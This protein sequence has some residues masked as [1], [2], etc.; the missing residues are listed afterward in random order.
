MKSPIL[1]TIAVLITIYL[2][3]SYSSG[4]LADEGGFREKKEVENGSS[5]AATVGDV[6]DG[7]DTPETFDIIGSG[8]NGEL[9][10]KFT[11]EEIEMNRIIT[12]DRNG[13][14]TVSTDEEVIQTLKRARQ[15]NL[16]FLRDEP[17]FSTKK[18]RRT[19]IGP[20][21]RFLRYYTQFNAPYSAVG[22]LAPD[23]CTAYLVGPRHLITAAHCVHPG[24]NTRA[25]YSG[26]QLTFYLR[27]NCYGRRHGTAFGVSEVLVYSQYRSSG[28][29]NY[30]IACLLLTS[31]VSDWMGYA[32]RDPMP[33]V[34]GE[35]C[36]YPEDKY[37]LNSIPSQCFYCSRCNDVRRVRTGW[38]GWGR[39][40]NRLE[41]TCDTKKGMS[42]SPV[43]TDD[44]D[45]SS[46]LYSYGVHTNEIL[47]GSRNK[48]VRITRN[49]FYDICRWKCNTGARCSVLC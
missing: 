11:Q 48:G 28:D 1:S 19:V 15:G 41:Y 27:R 29:S 3:I 42:G 5:T 12:I 40:N 35:I 6:R 2:S 4:E 38:F 18:R 34:S 21:N 26:S 43:M 14:E 25:I 17:H 37:R 32:Y 46:T 39:N 20:D 33:T 30:D 9:Y 7:E 47:G 8:S 36:G 13:N 23:K 45:S 49:Y 16:T 10:H 44:H 22:Y 31:T 24:T